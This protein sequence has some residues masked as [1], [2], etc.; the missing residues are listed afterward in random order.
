MLHWFCFFFFFSSRRRHTRCSRDWSSDV[1]SS[2][3]ADDAVIRKAAPDEGAHRRLG[4]V[5][6][7]GHG[8]EAAGAAFV[9]D[10]ER[11]A[12]ERQDGLPRYRGE[13]VHESRKID[14]RHSRAPPPLDLPDRL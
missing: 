3:L 11:R 10:A 4:R 14:W 7:R 13:L 12:E 5:I 6:G 9:L 2:D 1:C 8:I